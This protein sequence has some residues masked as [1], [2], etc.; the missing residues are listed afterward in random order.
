MK[1]I[2]WNAIIRPAL[3]ALALWAA[4]AVARPAL[5]AGWGVSA[6]LPF[7]SSLTLKPGVGTSGSQTLS[8]SSVSGFTAAVSLGWLGLDYEN[9][10][11]SFSKSGLKFDYDVTMYDILVNLPIPV[12]D[13]VLGGGVGN[14]SFSNCKI[15]GTGCTF[16]LKTANLTG[17]FASFGIPIFPLVDL[18]L[19]YHVFSGTNDAKVAGVSKETVSGDMY[20]LGIRVGF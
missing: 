6:D 4:L 18:H 13:I 11:N 15:A 8:D 3:L 12:V 9:Y 14:G 1:T 2:G 10:V 17:Y 16:Q 19:G 7:M 5:A 20:S